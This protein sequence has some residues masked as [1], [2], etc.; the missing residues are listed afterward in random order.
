MGTA[1]WDDEGIRKSENRGKIVMDKVRA[2]AESTTVKATEKTRDNGP[3]Y[4]E[5]S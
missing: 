2:R 4:P 5:Q 3:S 1:I